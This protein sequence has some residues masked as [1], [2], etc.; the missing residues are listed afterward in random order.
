MV[1]KQTEQLVGKRKDEPLVLEKIV[2]PRLMILIL[3]TVSKQP[4]HA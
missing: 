1:V 4:D 2:T 3:V